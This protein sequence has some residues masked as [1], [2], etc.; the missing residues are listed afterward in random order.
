MRVFTTHISMYCDLCV[1]FSVKMNSME[2]SLDLYCP[3]IEVVSNILHEYPDT[4]QES[5]INMDNCKLTDF[6]YFRYRFMKHT[7]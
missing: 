1:C 5:H 3:S 2:E 7:Q 4:E 6:T